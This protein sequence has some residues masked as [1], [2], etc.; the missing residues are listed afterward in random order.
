MR[1]G[2]KILFLY[3]FFFIIIFNCF[4]IGEVSYRVYQYFTYDRPIFSGSNDRYDPF[5]SPVIGH[6]LLHYVPNPKLPD[7]TPDFFRATPE[8]ERPVLRVV[9][10]GGSSTLGTSVLADEN[11]PSQL[12][13]LLA[14]S[15]V[16][17]K[18]HNAG[19][20]AGAWF[21]TWHDI[22]FKFEKCCSREMLSFSISEPMILE[23]C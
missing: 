11:Y 2:Q 10:L 1:D 8:I 21:T 12:Q 4:F 7:V 17:V 6:A 19:V 22:S 5:A 16:R 3:L 13:Q 20:R 23:Q 15:G 9:A 18:V 14:Q